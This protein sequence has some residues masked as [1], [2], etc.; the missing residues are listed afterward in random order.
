MVFEQIENHEDIRALLEGSALVPF[1]ETEVSVMSL[2][3]ISRHLERYT[4]LLNLIEVLGDRPLIFPLLCNLPKQ[5]KS[6]LSHMAAL[7]ENVRIL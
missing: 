2:V 7:V 1:L 6:I 5:K 3:E 4:A